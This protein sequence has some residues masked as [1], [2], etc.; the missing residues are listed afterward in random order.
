MINQNLLFSNYAVTLFIVKTTIW[1]VIKTVSKTKL[2][3]Y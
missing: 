2:E 3:K 1:S